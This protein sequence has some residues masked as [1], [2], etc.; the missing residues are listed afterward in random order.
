MQK[1]PQRVGLINK[2][3][4]LKSYRV[5]IPERQRGLTSE[6]NKARELR[7]VERKHLSSLL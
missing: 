5:F 6:F 4:Y 1:D 7:L 2:S 3:F